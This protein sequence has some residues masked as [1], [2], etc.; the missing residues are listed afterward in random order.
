MSVS[1]PTGRPSP[2]ARPPSAAGSRTEEVVGNF[3]RSYNIGRRMPQ[4]NICRRTHSE[5][6][7]IEA[8]GCYLCGQEGHFKK[9]CP[10]LG[11]QHNGYPQRTGMARGQPFRRRVSGASAS[12]RQ[13]KLHER[14]YP[15][16]DLELAAVVFA[17]KIWRHYLYGSKC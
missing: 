16:N 13:L 5:R 15:T 12:V 9:E 6:C 10:K 14:K 17:L 1:S 11:Q 7:K 2:Y 3:D 4:C 8:S